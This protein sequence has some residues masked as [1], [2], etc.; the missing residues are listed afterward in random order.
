MKNLR[1]SIF[2]GLAS[3]KWLQVLI[4]FELS[5]ALRHTDWSILRA[6]QD[7]SRSFQ[8]LDVHTLNKRSCT[9]VFWPETHGF[10]RHPL[11]IQLTNLDSPSTSPSMTKVNSQT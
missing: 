11:A 5:C 8:V 10:Q 7:S 2:R 4:R 9:V 6:K 1:D 3:S